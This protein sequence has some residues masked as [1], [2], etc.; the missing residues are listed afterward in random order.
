[1][2]FQSVEWKLPND[3]CASLDLHQFRYTPSVDIATHGEHKPGIHCIRSKT[4]FL[5][6]NI[7]TPTPDE[8]QLSNDFRYLLYIH[9]KRRSNATTLNSMKCIHDSD[10]TRP[11]EKGGTIY[12]ILHSE[13]LKNVQY[14]RDNERGVSFVI[15]ASAN[16]TVSNNKIRINSTLAQFF[17]LSFKIVYVTYRMSLDNQFAIVPD[18]I[19]QSENSYTLESNEM[20]EE[21]EDETMQDVTLLNETYPHKLFVQFFIEA[22]SNYRA[23]SECLLNQVQDPAE[24]NEL[25]WAFMNDDKQMDY[26][27]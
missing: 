23:A 9:G 27:S 14:W 16:G 17:P 2:S 7:S 12:K 3:I 24:M 11:P 10:Y 18:G 20:V 6:I 21:E 4:K 22:S 26:D 25:I 8:H 13:E 5:E 19:F 1:M 15:A